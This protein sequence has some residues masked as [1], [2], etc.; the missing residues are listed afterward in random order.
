MAGTVKRRKRGKGK[1][2]YEDIYK[3]FTQNS[4][5]DKTGLPESARAYWDELAEEVKSLPKGQYLD[6]P[7]EAPDADV[8][9]GHNAERTKEMLASWK[10]HME[11]EPDSDEWSDLK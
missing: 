7:F 5:F 9:H 2:P 1:V 4:D 8:D 3:A 11:N 10:Q 6:I